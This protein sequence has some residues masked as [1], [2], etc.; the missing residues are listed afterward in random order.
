MAQP[1]KRNASLLLTVSL[2]L[3]GSFAADVS[4]QQGKQGNY[5]I[6]VLPS[7]AGPWS[8]YADLKSADGKTL[9]KHWEE[10]HGK[11]KGYVEWN[12]FYGGDNARIDL[13]VS[14]YPG[15]P[16]E[17]FA[18]A[19]AGGNICIGHYFDN[20]KGVWITS[21]NVGGCS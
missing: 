11:D 15:A 2:C 16:L 7:P 14:A 9:F 18:Y 3:L 21:W 19:P 10:K 1:Q 20:Q 13:W 17:H 5:V 8:A 12:Y 6:R 4:A